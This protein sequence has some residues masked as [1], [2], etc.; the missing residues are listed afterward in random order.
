M[1]LVPNVMGPASACTI[2]VDMINDN[3]ICTHSMLLK[4]SVL[5]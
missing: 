1:G 4:L 5:V 2:R 3:A